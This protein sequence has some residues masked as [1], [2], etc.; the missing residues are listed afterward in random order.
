[1][2]RKINFII[3]IIFFLLLSS[4]FFSSTA[5]AQLSGITY[6]CNRGAP[7]ECTFAD[8]IEAV[9][10]LVNWGTIFALQFSV[11]VLAWAGFKYMIS[12]DNASERREANRLLTNVVKG[13][14]LIICAWVI[15]RLIITALG[16]TVPTFMS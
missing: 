13:I 12:G 11:V 2:T 3:P 1:M 5:H 7:G 14:I 4:L 10:A 8:L 6:V 15:V 16:V 9:K